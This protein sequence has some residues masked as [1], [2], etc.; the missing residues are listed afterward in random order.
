MKPL[1]VLF[2]K[3]TKLLPFPS[4]QDEDEPSRYKYHH[5][6]TIIYHCVAYR[7]T[8]IQLLRLIKSISARQIWYIFHGQEIISASSHLSHSLYLFK[9]FSFFFSTK[10]FMENILIE[11]DK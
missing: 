4:K 5:N 6:N 7:K 2:L 10:L 3:H 11:E 1:H 8:V 9:H